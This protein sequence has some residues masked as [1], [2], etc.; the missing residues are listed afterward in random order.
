MADKDSENPEPTQDDRNIAKVDA[1]TAGL[2]PEE[3]LIL[4]WK[5]YSTPVL[6]VVFVLLAIGA[7]NAGLKYWRTAQLQG[8]QKEYTKANLADEA[9]QK[10]RE[11]STNFNANKDLE[12]V[13]RTIEFA[14]KHP[15]DTLSGYAWIKAGHA[16]MK[17]GNFEEAT[18][19]YKAAL[20]GLENV[21]EIAG[22]AQLY[23]A[24]STYRSGDKTNGKNELKLLAE[25][26]DYLHSHRGEA[27]YKLGVIALFEK[28]ISDYENWEASLEN[29]NL[30]HSP[31]KWLEDL[32]TFRSQFPNKGFDELGPIPVKTPASTLVT[33]DISAS[34]GISSTGSISPTGKVKKK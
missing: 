11:E 33:G 29:A 15:N 21:P 22:L 19:H 12:V 25:N 34:G 27:Y 24:I 6:I 31:K 30:A 13:V 14:K 10:S 7:G 18:S 28:N 1:D 3:K 17:V 4:A 9:A 32:K 16:Y 26:K 5:K 20:V 2:S 8:I 23:H